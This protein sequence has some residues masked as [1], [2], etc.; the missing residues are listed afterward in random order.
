VIIYGRSVLKLIINDRNFLQRII[1]YGYF[2]FSLSISRKLLSFLN[3][4]HKHVG[5][6]AI[7]LMAGHALLMG[8]VRWNPF[9]I[10]VLLLLAWQGFF[11]LF[12][13]I[14]VPINPLK[15]Y[16]YLAHAQLFTG[17]MVGVFAI[18]GHLLV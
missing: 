17:V 1:P 3:R 12:L 11:G 5:A 7:V 16:G 4:S 14:R 9:L 18:F 10:L 6:T 2:D 13:V 8:A 15:R